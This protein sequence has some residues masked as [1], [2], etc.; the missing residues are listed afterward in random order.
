MLQ[1]NYASCDEQTHWAGY[2]LMTHGHDLQ[3]HELINE[4]AEAL[5]ANE[6]FS[7]TPELV[8]CETQRNPY[9]FTSR[10]QF[11][12]DNVTR[13]YYVK[14][15]IID[16]N[17]QD[18]VFSRLQSE[19]EHLKQ[20]RGTFEKE[21]HLSVATPI[22]YFARYPALVTEEV[23]GR[24]LHDILVGQTRLIGRSHA[25]YDIVDLCRLSGM[26]LSRFQTATALPRSHVNIDELQHYC[27]I[28]LD[29]ML[30]TPNPPIDNRFK[31]RFL[32]HLGEVGHS[33]LPDDNTISLRHNDFAP[34]NIIADHDSISVLDFT[35]CDAGETF[36]DIAAFWERLES[37]KS[38]PLHSSRKMR[39]LQAAF[40][41]GFG[42][43]IDM[44]SPGM[45]LGRSKFHLTQLVSSFDKHSSHPYHRWQERRNL[46]R[47]VS[48][49]EEEITRVV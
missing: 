22:A 35:M 6:C 39:E 42:E 32:S 28:R 17:N 13:S 20:F 37:F 21:A 30:R 1:A 4:L 43:T 15:P 41:A 18:V 10:L 19:F 33:I 34:H 5:S 29:A 27:E 11:S 23:R 2:Q 26:W 14:I 16:E 47:T 38:D 24:T 45:R 12:G 9:S 36:Y 46:G 31:S 25:N 49:L 8:S 44:D 48:W 3:L 40:L 7:A